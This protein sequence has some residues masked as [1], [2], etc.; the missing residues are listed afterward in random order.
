MFDPNDFD[1][2]HNDPVR[3]EELINCI[4]ETAAFCI[5]DNKK[6]RE[7]F[8]MVQTRLQAQLGLIV[9][10]ELTW[11]PPKV[12]CSVGKSNLKFSE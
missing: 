12:N 3:P 9:D 7:I 10:Y 11:I 5:Y 4:L 2:S 6:V 1:L 8:A